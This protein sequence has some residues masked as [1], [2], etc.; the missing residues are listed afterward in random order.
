M[1]ERFAPEVIVEIK[2]RT[3]KVP[4]EIENCTGILVMGKLIKSL[5]YSTDVSIIANHNADAIIA[6]YPFT[7]Q[8]YINDA[9]LDVASVPVFVGVGG[10]ATRGLRS[11]NIA[12]QAELHG[13]YGV[14]VN[15]PMD[16][17][18]IQLIRSR[19]DIPIVATIISKYDDYHGKIK[20]GAKILNISGGAETADLVKLIRK[21]YPEFPI[22]AT[23]GPTKQSIIDTIEAGANAI[24]YTPPSQA[25]IF[26]EVMEKYREAKDE[27]QIKE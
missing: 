2:S 1:S 14:V 18:N 26:G 13:A 6:V 17:E 10:G 20:A 12:L 8:L 4:K 25:E 16:N 19:V 24:T 7:P 27:Q 23:G 22:I 5:L 11:A 21:D 15:A 9:I 3:I